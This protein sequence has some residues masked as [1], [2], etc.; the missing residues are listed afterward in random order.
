MC[1]IYVVRR[2]DTGWY[3][4]GPYRYD[5][6]RRWTPNLEK[7]KKYKRTCDASNAV[8]TMRQGIGRGRKFPAKFG[9]ITYEL[10]PIPVDEREI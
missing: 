10:N 2:M 1:K 4:T 9:I 6:E 3:Y 8:N 5:F 7:A